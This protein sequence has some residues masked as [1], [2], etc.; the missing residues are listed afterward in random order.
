M[1]Q[2]MQKA[3]DKKRNDLVRLCGAVCDK[4]ERSISKLSPENS[5]Y[6]RAHQAILSLRTERDASFESLVRV[7]HGWFKVEPDKPNEVNK[8]EPD[9]P[10][11]VNKVELDKP[12]EINRSSPAFESTP[13]K[14]ADACPQIFV[15]RVAARFDEIKDLPEVKFLTTCS[16]AI[17]DNAFIGDF[18]IEYAKHKRILKKIS[19]MKSGSDST[20]VKIKIKV[21]FGS[22]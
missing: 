10:N 15:E 1:Q 21:R 13:C 14:Q 19:S 12:N 7:A 6:K 17:R 3:I 5:S 22:E 16:Q 9:K 8:V 11:E 18:V 4:E 2:Q 20:S